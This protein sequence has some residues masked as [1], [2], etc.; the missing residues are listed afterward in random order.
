MYNI[1]NEVIK[2]KKMVIVNCGK[3]IIVRK[4]IPILLLLLK[5]FPGD[6]KLIFWYF[7]FFKRYLKYNGY[8]F[9]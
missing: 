4:G 5:S 9:L 3:N 7:F 6:G 2:I 1:I 8:L